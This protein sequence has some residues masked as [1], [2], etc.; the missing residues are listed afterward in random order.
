MRTICEIMVQK[1]LP[2][3]RAEITRVMILEHGFSQQQI[4]EILNL[5]RAAVS[6]YMSEK[7]GAD[8]IFSQDILAKIHEFSNELITDS[9]KKQQVYGMCTICKFVQQSQWFI[10]NVPEAQSC[11]LCESML[12]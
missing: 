10:D 1:I 7:R 4:S 11:T 2:A 3:L 5:S 6:Q 12:N 9:N 8:I